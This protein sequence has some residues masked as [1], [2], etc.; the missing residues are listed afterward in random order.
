MILGRWNPH[1]DGCVLAGNRAR[2]LAECEPIDPDREV[3]LVGRA[4]CTVALL[5]KSA[6]RYRSDALLSLA[7][8]FRRMVS[9]PSPTDAP[10][11]PPARNGYVLVTSDM[12]AFDLL[13]GEEEC[14]GLQLREG[15]DGDPEPWMVHVYGVDAVFSS[16][17]KAR[18]WLGK[19]RIRFE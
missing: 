7:S 8:V 2:S 13:D 1:R 9:R 4:T 17:G 18:A 12:L 19:P 5:T 14:G 16:L 3:S 15:S 10:P 11:P 6:A